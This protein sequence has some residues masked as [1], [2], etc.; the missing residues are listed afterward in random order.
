MELTEAL[1][2]CLLSLL[3]VPRCRRAVTWGFG[4]WPVRI[5][6]LGAGS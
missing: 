3:R 5:C 6:A 2:T 1:R 4:A